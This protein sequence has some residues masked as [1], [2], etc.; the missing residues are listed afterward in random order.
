[1]RLD[2]QGRVGVALFGLAVV[3]SGVL[4]AATWAGHAWLERTLLDGIL[5]RELALY[6]D[7]GTAPQRVLAQHNGLTLYR[8][9][10]FPV[11]ALPA[12]LAT[13][14][15][16]SYRDLAL[17]GAHY[18]VLVRE[19]APRDR[20]YLMYD[21]SQ[22]ERREEW[23]RLALAAGLLLA[24]V[25]SWL[26]AR[27]LAHR[28]L[29][30]LRSVVG[31]IESLDPEQ[32]VP[33]P[34]H[35][36]DGDM[37]PVVAAVNHLL[38]ELEQLVQRERAF[39]GAAGHELRTPLT[40][41]RLAADALA[42]S[43]GV[44]AAPL[45]RIERA[46]QSAA[47][48]LDALL[49]LS[50]GRDVPGAQALALQRLLPQLAQPYEEAAREQGTRL[51]WR[52]H[53]VV[54]SGAPGVLAVIFTNLLRNAIRATH[55]GQIAIELDAAG[56]RVVDTGE[57]IAPEDLA[58]VFE[59]G[60]RGSHGGSGIG[61]Y[62]SRVLA[63]RCGWQLSLASTPGKGTTA[64]LRWAPGVAAYAAPTKALLL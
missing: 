48:T 14:R 22:V 40:S 5:E 42:A 55:A 28:L 3:V 41:I 61:L 56:L 20:A 43:P 63:Q 10:R 52:L 59:P 31:R 44:P 37:T 32:R 24:A 17:D 19:L 29:R 45:A 36:D 8:P 57:G 27:A 1:M 18:H 39:A 26:A 51:A 64:D 13:L 38:R 11:P 15:P 47:E 34:A 7:A 35:A 16:G 60:A 50:R 53:A 4:A 21:V 30:P 25:A 46:V 62:I 23:L 33:L 6:L 49:A 54:L 12:A 2:L 9:A 58:H